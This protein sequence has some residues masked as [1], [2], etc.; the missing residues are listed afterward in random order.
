MKKLDDLVPPLD[1]CKRI[2][3]GE[4]ADSVLVFVY[5]GDISEKGIIITRRHIESGEYVPWSNMS[6]APTLA[7]ILEKLPSHYKVRMKYSRDDKLVF[8]VFGGG[9]IESDMNAASAALK[10][11][12]KLEGIKA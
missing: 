9:I 12:L 7:E 11:W 10:V 8:S 1:L 2:P 6:P 3:A 4:F 5:G